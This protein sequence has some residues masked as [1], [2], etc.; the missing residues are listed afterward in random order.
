MITMDTT[1]HGYLD[2]GLITG[3]EAYMFAQDKSQFQEYSPLALKAEGAK[4]VDFKPSAVAPGKPGVGAAKPSS[5]TMQ[6]APA[7]AKPPSG[8]VQAAP[9]A[10]AKPVQGPA[11]PVAAAPAKVVT[12]TLPSKSPSSTARPV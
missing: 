2:Q 7:V 3:T 8:T 5:G 4:A 10:P 9:A 12:G 11:K 6:A 1:I